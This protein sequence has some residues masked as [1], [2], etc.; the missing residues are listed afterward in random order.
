MIFKSP[1]ETTH[2]QL[3]KVHWGITRRD[4]RCL[5]WWWEKTA[6]RLA[7]GHKYSSSPSIS[8]RIPGTCATIQLS[9]NEI[10]ISLQFAFVIPPPTAPPLLEHLR[11]IAPLTLSSW[12]ISVAAI[13][14]DKDS[15]IPANASGRGAILCA[16]RKGRIASAVFCFP[17][18]WI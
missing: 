17:I 6:A 16:G 14:S 8:P 18:L 12:D 11:P 15:N 4:K 5:G 1:V 10:P 3:S 7:G 9:R 13:S 2:R